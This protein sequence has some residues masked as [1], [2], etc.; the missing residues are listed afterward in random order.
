M[1][2]QLYI[3]RDGYAGKFE[4]IKLFPKRIRFFKNDDCDGDDLIFYKFADLNDSGTIF[5]RTKKGFDKR[6]IKLEEKV[7]FQ[8]ALEKMKDGY[9]ADRLKYA[10]TLNAIYTID[11]MFTYEDM[12]ANDWIIL[13]KN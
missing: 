11:S 4:I 9:R 2:N 12:I 1:N 7:S 3:Y 13:E 5:A 10:N 6:F 8:E